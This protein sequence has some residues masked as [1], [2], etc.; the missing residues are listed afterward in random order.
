GY[1]PDT[2][3]DDLPVSA[4]GWAPRNDNGE[5][6]GPIPLRH[7]LAKSVNSV[8]ARLTLE[9][10]PS[11]IARTA[12][13]LGIR[14][15]LAKDATLALGTSEVS[16]LELAGAYNIL[17]NGGHRA[18]PYIIRRVRSPRGEVLMAHQPLTPQQ[19]VAPAHV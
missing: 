10:G 3:V 5:Y 4:G 19:L 18:E 13:R 9:L 1:T 16:L 7:A 12:Q 11:R 17:A 8:A 15:P 2:M 14:S 6:L